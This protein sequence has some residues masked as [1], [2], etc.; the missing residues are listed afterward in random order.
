MALLCSRSAYLG[1]RSLQAISGDLD[2]IRGDRD[3]CFPDSTCPRK[4]VLVPPALARTRRSSQSRGNITSHLSSVVVSTSRVAGST[5]RLV[6]FRDQ[7]VAAHS[8]ALF[9]PPTVESLGVCG[10]VLREACCT[11]RALPLRR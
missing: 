6:V 3:R 11:R 10:S 7:H 9:V 1:S 5:Q 8:L 2:L 4:E